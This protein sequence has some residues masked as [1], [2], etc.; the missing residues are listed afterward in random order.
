MIQFLQKRLFLAY[1]IKHSF[2]TEMSRITHFTFTELLEL[3][4]PTQPQPLKLYWVG[5]VVRFTHNQI[6]LSYLKQVRFLISVSVSLL[7]ITTHISINRF[8]KTLKKVRLLG[9]LLVKRTHNR[10]HNK[11]S[12]THI[13]I[14]ITNIK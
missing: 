6:S 12:P 3:K 4:Q 9:T 1:L 10:T 5:L 11:K 8:K 14:C 13:F 7:D 2:L